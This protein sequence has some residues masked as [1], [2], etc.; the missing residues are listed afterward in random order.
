MC[1]QISWFW[2]PWHFLAILLSGAWIKHTQH[3]HTTLELATKR[4]PLP[5]SAYWPR[6][7]F[8]S[9]CRTYL[10]W[11]PQTGPCSASSHVCWQP[12]F[13]WLHVTGEK[14]HITSHKHFQHPWRT[15]CNSVWAPCTPVPKDSVRLKHCWTLSWRER[16]HNSQTTDTTAIHR[17]VWPLSPLGKKTLSGKTVCWVFS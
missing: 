7:V 13:P 15:V 10:G 14:T 5:C 12:P 17:P 3:H 8:P 1:Y 4:K 9:R 11:Q 6:Q 16:W 2:T